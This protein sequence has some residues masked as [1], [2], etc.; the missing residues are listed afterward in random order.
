MTISVKI[1]ADSVSQEGIRLTTFQLCYPRIIHSELMTHRVFSRNASS[2]RAIPISRTIKDIL[3]DP[4]EPLKWGSNKPGMQ[5]G[6]ELSGFKQ[7][8]VRQAWH[9]TK[10]CALLGARISQW[11]GAHKQVANRILEPWSHISVVLTSTDFSNWFALRCHEN[12]DPTI[13]QLAAEMGWAYRS[14]MP[15]PLQPGGWHLPYVDEDIDLETA[16]KMSAARCARVSYLNHDGSKPS[17]EADLKLFDYL[18]ADAPVHASPTEHQATPDKKWSRNRWG[19]PEL[20]G[21]FRGWCQFRKTIP[22][23]VVS[24]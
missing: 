24:E 22:N 5:A 10:R 15:E 3:T 23:E 8:L 19:K 13:H 17:L 14:S 7:W 16:K 6:A 20:H 11:A 18:V 2:S 4:A 9:G 21:N 12:A 1:I